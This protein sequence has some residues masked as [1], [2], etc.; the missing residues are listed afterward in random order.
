M[1]LS[2]A[3]PA[4]WIPDTDGTKTGSESEHQTHL[5]VLI[6]YEPA[7]V[8]HSLA[9]AAFSSWHRWH[10]AREPLLQELCWVL[11]GV[12]QHPHLHPAGLSQGDN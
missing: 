2:A 4:A 1:L 3:A 10:E 6:H 12:Q 7:T 11:Q 5:P 8:Y 9:S